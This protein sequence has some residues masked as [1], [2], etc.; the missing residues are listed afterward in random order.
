MNILK[1]KNKWLVTGGAGFIGSHLIRDLIRQNQKVVCVDDFSTGSDKNLPESQLLEVI[2]S[3]IQNISLKDLAP[4]LKG[5]FHLAAQSSAPKSI[6]SMYLSSSNNLLSSLKVWDIAREL[7]IPIVY[8][9]SSAIY[10]N[11]P[12]GDDKLRKIDILSPYAM[13][14]LSM[15]NYAKVCWDLYD[16]SSIGLRFFNVYGPR[17]D[18][19]NPYS[20]V[21]SIFLDRLLS[22]RSVILNGGYQTRDFIFVRDVSKVLISSMI[23]SLQNNICSFFNV[24]TGKS[25]TISTLLTE[26]SS[27]LDIQPKIITKELPN[28]DPKVS[29]CS[30]V[31]L[32]QEMGI[33]THQFYSLKKGLKSSIRHIKSLSS[34]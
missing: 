10:G 15:E 18:P 13:D 26:I 6:E 28:G 16:V 22:K 27:I 4:D 5:I 23:F 25:I 31:K 34:Q 17:Q 30:T 19:L 12:R 24:G 20:G 21:I 3:K 9:S 32:E 7:S 29:Q 1:N 33:N 14:K 8:A 2:N 11:L